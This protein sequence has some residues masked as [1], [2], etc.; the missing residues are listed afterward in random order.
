MPSRPR[1]D[2]VARLANDMKRTEDER[3][4]QLSELRQAQEALHASE[5]KFRAAFEGAG[6]GIH[7]VDAEGRVLEHNNVLTA[8]LGYSDEELRGRSLSEL[9]DPAHAAPALGALRE[10]VEG[11]RERMVE[12]RH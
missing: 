7:F 3:A 2:D 8:M 6:M 1:L 9:L 10:M 12:E 4:G 11:R 5:A